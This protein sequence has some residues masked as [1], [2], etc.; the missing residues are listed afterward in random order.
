MKKKNTIIILIV[1]LL[2]A[3]V[4]FSACSDVT[5]EKSRNEEF[6][7]I[8]L[9]TVGASGQDINYATV[10]EHKNGSFVVEIEIEGIRYDVTISEDHTVQSVKINDHIVDKE[11]LPEA[12]F[13]S[14]KYIGKERAKE[15]AFSD[16]GVGIDG[17]TKLEVEFDFDDGK[18]LYEVEFKIGTA[19]YEYD[20]DALSGEIHKKE[21]NDT[22]VYIQTPDGVSFISTEDATAIA[23]ENALLGLNNSTFTSA[24]ATVTK[25]KLDYEKG[26]Y[27]F[28]I[29]FYLNGNEYEYEINATTG[30]VIKAEVEHADKDDDDIIPD[31]KY[32]TQDEA[33]RIA[34][35]MAGVDS[36]TELETKLEVEHGVVIYEVEFKANGFEYEYEIDAK[37]GAILDYEV[38]I[39]D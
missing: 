11:E 38:E 39:D 6:K 18:Y 12:P 2:C 5:D 31:A 29:E 27:V 4:I 25:A 20:I 8:A 9:M 19:K 3:C 30:V 13:A 21:V 28:E 14:N 7:S 34:I 15:V 23:V 22:T 35:G 10:T 17:V 37:T 16:A 32:I 24:D 26:A 33:V 1:T 36:Y